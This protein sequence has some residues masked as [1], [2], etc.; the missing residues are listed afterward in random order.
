MFMQPQVSRY[1]PGL[2]GRDRIERDL[3]ALTPGQRQFFR[4]VIGVTRILFVPV[5]V[6]L[7]LAWALRCL[8][9]VL[10]ERLPPPVGHPVLRRA[11]PPPPGSELL[12]V[13][14]C[15]LYLVGAAVAVVLGLGAMIGMCFLPAITFLW[16]ASALQG[17]EDLARVVAGVL[18]GAVLEGLMLLVYFRYMRGILAGR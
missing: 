2:S 9:L 7:R 4:L 6:L 18:G 1:R 14:G 13:P 11:F 12:E 10:A 15:P 8:G 3:A 17:Q 5:W 16:A